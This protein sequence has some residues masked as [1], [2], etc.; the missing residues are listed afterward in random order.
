MNKTLELIKDW[1]EC[2]DYFKSNT[3]TQIVKLLEEAG[4]LAKA[5]IKGDDEMY[6]DSI[7]DIV[8]V[9]LTLCHFK[10]ITLEECITQAYYDIKDREYTI[11]DEGAYKRIK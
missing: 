1:L 3:D 6:R 5:R 2:Q 9:L 8:V 11:T 7:G 4:E 10:G